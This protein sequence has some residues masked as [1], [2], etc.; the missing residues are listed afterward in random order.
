MS[1][2]NHRIEHSEQLVHTGDQCHLF[3]LALFQQTSIE[4]LD[5][6]IVSHCHPRPHVQHRSHLGAAAPNRPPTSL[7]ATLVIEGSDP[8][9]SA[10]AFVINLSQ[11]W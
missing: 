4:R 11:F 1:V 2:P 8:D 5:H 7:L 9:Q 3:C 6:W 10:E